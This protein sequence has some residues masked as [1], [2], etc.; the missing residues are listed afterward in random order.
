MRGLHSS[1]NQM[2]KCFAKKSMMVKPHAL[3]FYGGSGPN[4]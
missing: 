4:E 3:F 2:T 1:N